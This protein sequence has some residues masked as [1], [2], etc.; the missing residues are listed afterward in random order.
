MGCGQRKA[1]QG[2]FSCWR[3]GCY[4]EGTGTVP[5]VV[6]DLVWAQTLAWC[7][8]EDRRSCFPAQSL[9]QSLTFLPTAACAEGC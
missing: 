4:P 6:S 7:R 5:V 2:A 3:D 9:E 8:G 1:P